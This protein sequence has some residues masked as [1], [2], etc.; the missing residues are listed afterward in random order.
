MSI[1]FTSSTLNYPITASTAIKRV[2]S[3]RDPSGRDGAG[4]TIGDEWLNSSTNIWFKLARKGNSSQSSAIW[5]EIGAPSE[6]HTIQGN[7]GGPIAGNTSGNIFIMG[8]P[9]INVVGNPVTNTLMINAVG[10]GFGWQSISSNQSLLSEKG[11]F[12]N[13]ASR[14]NLTLPSICNVG[15]AIQ[16]AAINANGWRIIPANGQKIQFGVRFTLAGPT[17]YIQSNRNGN[18]V[19]LICYVANSLW[20]V[21]GSHGNITIV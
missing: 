12:T 16:V 9:G 11:Y 1:D 8:S 2:K 18:W 19:S 14:L 6:I 3:D 17:G 5:V 20:V 13:G 7:S 4:Y 15:D 10:G 21:L